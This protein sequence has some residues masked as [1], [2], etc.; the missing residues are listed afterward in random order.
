VHWP[1]CASLC[2][3]CDFDKQ[4]SDF[5]LADQYIEALSAHLIQTPPRP[6]HSLYFGGG[7]PSL[8]RPDRLARIV[9]AVRNH[10][11]LLPDAEV[12]V[13][14]NP[15]D[16]AVPKL[17]AYFEAGVNRISLGVQ[18]LVDEELRFLGRRH[19]ADKAIRA[20]AALREAGCRNLSLDLMYG[21]PHQT[22]GQLERS[23]DGLLALEPE[24][25]S[26][27]ALTLEDSTPMG[28]DLAEG[29]LKLP[30]DDAVAAG[31][32]QIQTVFGEAGFDQYEVSNWARPGFASTH[33]LTYWRNDEYLGLGAGAAGS[34][35]GLRY[36]RNPD[37][38]AYIA[39]AKEGDAALVESEPWT[40]E[41]AMHDTVMLGLRLTEGI[42]DAEFAERFGCSLAD[43]CTDRLSE[44]VEERV[45][46]WQ[47]GR[48]RLAPK[49][50]FVSNAVLGEILP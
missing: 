10:M 21:V 50:F 38:R 37:L 27:Y 39:A 3:Y 23:L 5:D 28:R 9:E 31:Y 36:K 30:S 15:S 12:T 26:A 6:A 7:T 25:I 19:T 14:C 45:L 46:G 43:Y 35:D 41:Q 34:C 16:V 40:R 47:D 1:W 20:V 24:H 2:P 29:R 32:D 17:R 13:E 18:S 42:S 11:D 33:N 49:Y 48:L 22:R 44:L 8:L 4:A